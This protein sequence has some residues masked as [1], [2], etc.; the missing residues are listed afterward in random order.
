MLAELSCGHGIWLSVS[1]GA[2]F[3]FFI[4]AVGRVSHTCCRQAILQVCNMSAAPAAVPGALRSTR[5]TGTQLKIG[6]QMAADIYMYKLLDISVLDAFKV[7]VMTTLV[8]PTR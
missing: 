8:T 4:A 6:S 1:P 2:Y 7:W 5:S 3:V